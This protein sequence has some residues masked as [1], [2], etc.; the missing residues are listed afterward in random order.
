MLTR[1]H[2]APYL[3]TASDPLDGTGRSKGGYW[4]IGKNRGVD[5]DH[6]A[7]ASQ[8]STGSTQDFISDAAHVG[9]SID[10]LIRADTHLSENA[11]SPTFLSAAD[12]GPGHVAHP[13]RLG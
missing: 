4:S 8:H 10:E 11:Q 1:R 2:S 13:R 9:F 5:S 7:A 12:R 3:L 6:E